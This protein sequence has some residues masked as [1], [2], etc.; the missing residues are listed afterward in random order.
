LS[1]VE[2]LEI[3]LSFILYIWANGVF[4]FQK[5]GKYVWS[6]RVLF[7][8]GLI[9][10]TIFYIFMLSPSGFCYENSSSTTSI[11]W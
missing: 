6:R 5:I 4:I 8:C 7:D 9:L 10:G 3:I 1:H 11:E 2:I